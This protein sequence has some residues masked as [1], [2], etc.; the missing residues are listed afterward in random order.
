L[1][2]TPDRTSRAAGRRA[3]P[4]PGGRSPAPGAL[5]LVQA[6]VNSRWDLERELREQLGSPAELAGW[7][8]DHGLLAAGSRVTRKELR[9]ALEVRE[10]LRALLFANNGA[11][12]DHAA[13]ER[14]NR[15]LG[16]TGLDLRFGATGA[17]SFEPSGRGVDGALAAIAGIVAASQLAGS[18][19]RLKAC[20][21]PHCGWAFYDHS[22]NHSGSWCSMSTCGSRIKAREYRRRKRSVP[23]SSA[24]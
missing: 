2:V 16:A 5:A 10:G 19:P 20:P 23:D 11:P 9:R 3:E 12:P 4:Q 13:I 18:W 17:A 21:G 14:L 7:L 6:F 15:A 24:R 22:R 1:P 8:T